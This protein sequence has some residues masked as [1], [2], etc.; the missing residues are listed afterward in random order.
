[1]TDNSPI[2]VFI[3]AA[4]TAE[5]EHLAEALLT[6]HLA[7]CVSILPEVSS[8]FWWRGKIESTREVLLTVKSRDHLLEAI[9]ARVKKLHSYEVPEIIALPIVGGNADYLRWIKDET[10][11]RSELDST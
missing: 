1:M 7:A 5:A 4:D 2:V 8:R 10:A 11:H 6:A 3:T 9:I